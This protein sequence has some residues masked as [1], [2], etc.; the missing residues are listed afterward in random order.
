MCCP[1]PCV[2]SKPLEFSI[3]TMVYLFV[4]HPVLYK[5]ITGDLIRATSLQVQGSVRPSELDAAGWRCICTAFHGASRELCNTV[6]VM[7]RQISSSIVEPA[8]LTAFIASQL[9]PL[10]KTPGARP[11]GICETIH[12]I[13]CKAV[14]RHKSRYTF[15]CWSPSGLCRPRHRLCCPCHAI[16]V[17]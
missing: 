13:M 17:R 2:R 16:R 1:P 3:S 14:L 15:C 6:V 9:I 7:T 4:T 5:A 12:R 10:N 8:G 11:I